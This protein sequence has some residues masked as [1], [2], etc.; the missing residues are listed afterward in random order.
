MSGQAP[1]RLLQGSGCGELYK[2]QQH[3]A[4]A[5]VPAFY[6]SRVTRRGPISQ[7]TALSCYSN[8]H[9]FRTV[10]YP[11]VRSTSIK[12]HMQLHVL[13]ESNSIVHASFIDD[14]RSHSLTSHITEHPPQSSRWPRRSNRQTLCCRCSLIILRFSNG[15][16]DS[17]A[18]GS[19]HG[20]LSFSRDYSPVM[21]TYLPFRQETA[22]K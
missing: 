1:S 2:R 13:L 5:P 19:P 17:I 9:C 21:Q 10:S 6:A 16:P 7:T 22:I 15:C 12:L 14:C 8:D 20:V 11:T 18:V 3:A 4:P